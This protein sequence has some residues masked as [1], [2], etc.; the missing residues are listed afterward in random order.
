MRT[1]KLVSGI[2]SL[3][4]F[5]FVVFQSCAAGIANT[6]SAN[7]EISGSA[8]VLVALLMLVGGI[9][10]IVTRNGGLIPNV[11]LI[12][13]YGL[14]AVCGFS[15]A[16]S[17]GDL[18]IWSAWCAVCAVIAIVSAVRSKPSKDHPA[19]VK[20]E[21]GGWNCP[22]CGGA[23]RPSKKDEDRMLCDKCRKGYWIGDL[24][25]E[26]EDGPV[27]GKTRLNR[28]EIIVVAIIIVGAVI[29]SLIFGSVIG[30]L[31]VR[32]RLGV[33]DTIVQDDPDAQSGG[34]VQGNSDPVSG[35]EPQ[36][37]EPESHQTD[38]GTI[39]FNGDGY[40]VTYARHET[41]TDYEGDPCLYYYYTFTNNGEENTSAAVASY[42]QCF[43]NGVQCQTAITTDSNDSINNYMMDVQPGGSLE[44]CQVFELTDT[45]DVT[46]E[47]SDLISLSDNK[48][49]QIIK[50]Q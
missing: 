32:Q 16:G 28:N 50:L 41:G 36:Q 2:L 43:Q 26:Y 33:E 34:N 44:V 7:G 38:S 39:D 22:V 47:A 49:T 30:T 20:R 13:L 10:S 21:D 9:V 4:L 17:Y 3:V 15:L 48:D 45:S 12:I 27:D 31:V 46:I 37:A 35:N 1:W 14:A 11:A 5:V 40:N 18:Y 24:E 42:I 25:D 6:L 19:E 23:L 29:V 8:G